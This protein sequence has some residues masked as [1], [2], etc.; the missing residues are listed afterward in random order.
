MFDP[1]DVPEPDHAR[2]R[3][4]Y[5]RAR[6]L[7]LS[8][9]AA[10]LLFLYSA[11]TNAANDQ[12]CPDVFKASVK[13]C[14]QLL[15]DQPHSS[16][17]ANAQKACV[18]DAR[19]A[20]RKCMTGPAPCLTACQTTYDDSLAICQVNYNG[21][22]PCGGDRICTDYLNMKAACESAAVQGLDTC[23]MACQLP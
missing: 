3:T 20:R 23:S 10:T 21:K 12:Q 22:N 13:A 7:A 19:T 6:C 5:G 11:T 8:H 15:N 4:I 1:A 14:A 2:M 17:K 9:V 16:L 18:I